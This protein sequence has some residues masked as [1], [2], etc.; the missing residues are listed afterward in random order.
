MKAFKEI[1]CREMR[2]VSKNRF[3]NKIPRKHVS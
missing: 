2:I 3:A 1:M